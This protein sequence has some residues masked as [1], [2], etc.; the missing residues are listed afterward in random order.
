MCATPT[1]IVECAALRRRCGRAVRS[2]RTAATTTT[3]STAATDTDTA[4]TTTVSTAATR[5]FFTRGTFTFG[6][7]KVHDETSTTNVDATQSFDG[8][9]GCFGAGHRDKPEAALATVGIHGQVHAND[10]ACAGRRDHRFDFFDARVVRQV[11]YVECAIRCACRAARR[12]AEAAATAASTTAHAA[13]TT[14]P[15]TTT[16]TTKSANTGLTTRRL[17]L[18]WSNRDRL[19]S[20]KRPIERLTCRVRLCARRERHEPE[21]TRPPSRAILRQTHFDDIAS[22]GLE[23]A[24]KHIFG[25]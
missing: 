17:G 20:L 11:A 4:A 1:T 3:V 8:T 6:M 2:R 12:A 14:R 13:V 5:A 21:T 15:A 16:G 9:F 25:D 23:K 18:E 10:W 24:P 22:S 19:A 7:R